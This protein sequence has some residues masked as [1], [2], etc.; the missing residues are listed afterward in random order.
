MPMDHDALVGDLGMGPVGGSG[1]LLLARAL[2]RRPRIRFMEGTSHLGAA[3]EREANAAPARLE[4]TRIVIAHRPETIAMADRVLVFE[5]G[6]FRDAA[7]PRPLA[8]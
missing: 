6:R 5:G 1:S 7:A 3:K 8:A 4:I 2:Y